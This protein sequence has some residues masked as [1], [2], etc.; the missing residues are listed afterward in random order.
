VSYESQIE[1]EG[2]IFLHHLGGGSTVA[3][4]NHSW[5]SIVESGV[6]GA[7]C[8]TPLALASGS[9]EKR[10]RESFLL[11]DKEAERVRLGK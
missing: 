5:K 4:E 6:G 10:E 7:R 8:S 1:G 3:T 2:G 9:R 11:Q